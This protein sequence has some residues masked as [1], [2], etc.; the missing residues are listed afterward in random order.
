MSPPGVPE[1]AVPGRE[2][3]HDGRG[4]HPLG[5]GR[6]FPFGDALGEEAAALHRSER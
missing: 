6:K 4:R 2:I 5:D 3:D 1:L